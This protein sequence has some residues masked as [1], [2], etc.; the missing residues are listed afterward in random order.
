MKHLQLIFAA[1]VIT[2][3]LTSS[4]F[5]GDIGVGRSTAGDIGVGQAVAAGDIGVGRVAATGDIGVG[6]AE[7]REGFDSQSSS[8]EFILTAM[9]NTLQNLLPLF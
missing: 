3:A 5:A 4:T 7:A 9:L 1:A 6:K 2:C 8:S